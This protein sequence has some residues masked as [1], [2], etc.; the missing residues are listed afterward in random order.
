MNLKSINENKNM[1][2]IN[3]LL[4]EKRFVE[5]KNKKRT[6]KLKTINNELNE[7]K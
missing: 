4:Y 2:A 6:N 5:E 3:F 7:I 1:N